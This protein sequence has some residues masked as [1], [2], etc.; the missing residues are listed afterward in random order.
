M[1]DRWLEVPT[2]YILMSS[3]CPMKSVVM[4]FESLLLSPNC[5]ISSL[6]NSTII[7]GSP[8]CLLFLQVLESS[9]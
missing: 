4:P 1:L 9:S 8:P 2:S 7:L 6:V 3:L 5:L